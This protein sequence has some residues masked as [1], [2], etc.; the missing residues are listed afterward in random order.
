MKVNLRMCKIIKL[1]VILMLLPLSVSAAYDVKFDYK[2]SID[3]AKDARGECIGE[4]FLLSDLGSIDQNA[5]E[6][7]CD[8]RK[9]CSGYSFKTG[10][11]LLRKNIMLCSQQDWKP[12]TGY[13]YYAKP[14]E[15]DFFISDKVSTLNPKI[16]TDDKKNVLKYCLQ[17]PAKAKEGD[18]LE[19]VLCS[20]AQGHKGQTFTLIDTTNATQTPKVYKVKHLDSGLCID[21]L[22][23]LID[24]NPTRLWNCD[25]S[26]ET[27]V[28]QERQLFKFNS[29]EIPKGME[30]YTPFKVVL[31]TDH[32]LS[33]ISDY[34]MIVTGDCVGNDLSQ[35]PNNS[36]DECANACSANTACKGFSYNYDNKRCVLKTVANCTTRELN[37]NYYFYSKK[38]ELDK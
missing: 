23:F 18:K 36:S 38:S 12:D 13:Q 22:E 9:Q 33:S 25:L 31:N 11:C 2:G 19:T 32:D 8:D 17:V 16:K 15:L 29:T 7:A 14:F 34:F 6:T 21:L 28:R 3:Y 10:S 1:V 35:L 26:K 5:C 37:G 20:V 27:A 4:H 24:D 30:N